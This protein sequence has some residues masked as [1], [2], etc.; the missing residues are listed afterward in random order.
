MTRA[1]QVEVRALALLRS[2]V[3][4]LGLAAL[5]CLGTAS[6]LACVLEG[7]ERQESVL[8]VLAFGGILL[9]LIAGHGMISGDLRSGVAM[10]WLQK[11]VSPVLHFVRRALEVTALGAVLVMAFWGVGSAITAACAGVAAGRELLSAAPAML[12]LS[13]CLCAILFG[14]SAW[15]IQT[16]TLFV[17]AFFFASTL[18]LLAGGRLAELLGW[19]AL[20]VEALGTVAEVLGGER[21]E[22]VGQAFLLL[23]RFLAV[24]VGIGVAG[25][26]VSTRSP[27]PRE[28]SR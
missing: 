11:P 20:P 22:H 1:L 24:W 10:L 14:F 9:P 19:L 5:A 3:K 12:L 4:L 13:V 15:G 7:D 26:V 6:V 25:L 27:L 17:A 8:E 2:R 23:A 21:R 18:S 16:D 28:V